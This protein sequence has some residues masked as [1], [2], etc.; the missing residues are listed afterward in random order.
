M[1]AINIGKHV[2]DEFNCVNG[3]GQG[4]PSPS[5][6]H[7]L[8]PPSSSSSWTATFLEYEGAPSLTTATSRG[9]YD[10]IV[11]VHE[12]IAKFDK[13]AGLGTGG[14]RIHIRVIISIRMLENLGNNIS[15]FRYDFKGPGAD[16][17]SFFC[18]GCFL[19]LESQ[20]NSS[21]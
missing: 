19:R 4:D 13:A 20:N 16:N 2:G 17:V 8:S 11:K 5:S 15:A 21:F 6:P 3:V 18:C 1:K 12:F 9:S 7:L 10:D 14:W